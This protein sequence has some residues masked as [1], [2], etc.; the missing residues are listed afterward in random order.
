MECDY[1]T[2]SYF[3]ELEKQ[4]QAEQQQGG[5]QERLDQLA[6]G[7]VSGCGEDGEALG[8]WVGYG[9]WQQGVGMYNIVKQK[10]AISADWK[11]L[12]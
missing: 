10:R 12:C 5:G 4:Y 9:R 2:P 1:V 3:R 8:G 7:G 6:T 11:S